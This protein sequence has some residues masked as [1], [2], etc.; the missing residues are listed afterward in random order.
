MIR[1]RILQLEQTLERLFGGRAPREPLEIR[2]AVID[3]L[4]AQVRPV[5]RG[6]RVLPFSR[7]TI[8][9]VASDATERRV[10]K[11]ALDPED[12]TREL[13]LDIERAGGQTAGLDL[14]VRFTREAGRAWLPGARFHITVAQPEE[15]DALPV[16]E[17]G[18]TQSVVLRVLEG[19]GRPRTLTTDA[20]RINIGRQVDVVDPSGRPIR[21]NDVAFIGDDDVSRSVSRAHAFITVDA[22]AG[23]CRV[24]DENSAH[25]TQV[26]REGRRISVPAGRDGLRLRPGDEIHLGRAVLRFDVRDGPAG[27]RSR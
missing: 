20:R 27:T 5:G 15:D 6:R 13:L 21:R 7:A 10:L 11:E 23:S 16:G 14:S 25:G 8:Q 24:F 2:R 12:L 17:G 18:P 22:G 26:E 3:A 9:V 19:D 1:E 4:V